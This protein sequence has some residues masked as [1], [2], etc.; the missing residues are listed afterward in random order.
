LNNPVAIPP[1][2]QARTWSPRLIPK[3]SD[4]RST[5]IDDPLIVAEGAGAPFRPLVK[6]EKVL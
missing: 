4:E 2:F 1:I 3:K 5:E 6:S